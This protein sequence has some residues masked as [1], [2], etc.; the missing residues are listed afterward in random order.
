M[1][2]WQTEVICAGSFIAVLF[3]VMGPWGLVIGAVVAV[4]SFG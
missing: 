3:L 4:V 1:K 2:R